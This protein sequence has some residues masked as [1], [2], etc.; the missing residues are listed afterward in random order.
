M[1]LFMNEIE[2]RYRKCAL[3]VL[4]ELGYEKVSVPNSP[5]IG[6]VL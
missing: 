2:E 1:V 5:I 3:K 6:G 4:E